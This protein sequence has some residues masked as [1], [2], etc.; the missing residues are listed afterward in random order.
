MTAPVPA[1]KPAAGALPRP[2]GLWPG[3]GLS[4]LGGLAQTLAWP[5]FGLWPLTFLCLIPLWRAI[6]GQGF[7]RAFLFGWAYGMALGLSG[8]YWLAGVMAGYGGLGPAGGFLVLLVLAAYLALYNGLW[9]AFMSQRAHLEAP[10]DSRLLGV[11]MLGA[12]L[13][14]G[15]DYLKNFVF[16]GF[17]WTPLAGGLS[18]SLDFIGAA[19][20]V[21]VYGLGFPVALVSILLAQIFA[22]RAWPKRTLASLATAVLLLVA[23][24]GYGRYR[25]GLFDDLAQ[26]AAGGG[27]RSVSILQA[28]VPQDEKWDPNF[29]DEILARFASLL[30]ASAQAKP[31]LTIWPET[32]VPFIYGLDPVETAWMD[33]TLDEFAMPMLVGLA[34][35]DYD[36]DG[37]LRLHNR[38]WLVS[39]GKVLGTYDKSHL[40]PFGEYVPLSDVLPFLRWP[41]LQ[42][43]LGAAGT[44]SPGLKKPPMALDGLRLGQ[45]ICFESIFPGL[46]RDRARA[47]A[48]LLIVTTNDAW[49]NLTMAPD[50]H[51]A[52]S[53]LRAVET[54][55]PLVRAANNGISA[56]IAPSGRITH[57]SVQNEIRA[58][59]WPLD[60]P[61][62][63]PPTLFSRGGY[64]VA[65]LMGLGTALFC[66]AWLYRAKLA[67]RKAPPAGGAKKKR[68]VSEL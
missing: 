63:S 59:V 39:G 6:F 23:M 41:F 15:F 35:G 30:G 20:L 10:L 7:K 48:D 53:A 11:P 25:L 27:K 8:F 36:E 1:A 67:R 22:Y 37:R 38:A 55:L 56:I 64:L 61:P 21:G 54:R 49:F 9:A 3:L 60:L 34:S 28:S 14:V 13:W 33:Q 2:V 19:D 58:L 5:R 45:L 26:A 66:L 40:V 47:G 29:R 43:V 32:A 17:N 50:Q 51:L 65:P 42:G 46:A 44:Y 4:A 24:F 12:F 68:F 52:H 16:T 18:G 31:W 57:R 62:K